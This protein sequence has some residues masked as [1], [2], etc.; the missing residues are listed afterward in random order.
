MARGRKLRIFQEHT[1]SCGRDHPREAGPRNPVRRGE[2]S[3]G[4]LVLASEAGEGPGEE[5]FGAWRAGK[6]LEISIP[7]E[8]I[9]ARAGEALV[10]R[11]EAVRRG[12]VLDRFP[13]SGAF[14]I[15]VPGEDFEADS[16]FV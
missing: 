4:A 5:V 3:G 9:G 13:R 7:C 2:T 8:K 16:W 6:T 14:E 10:F 1:V 11:V 12:R 15:R